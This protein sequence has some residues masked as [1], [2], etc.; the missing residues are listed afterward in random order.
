M[1]EISDPAYP[2]ERLMVC[3]NPLLAEQRARKRKELLDATER[4]VGPDPPMRSS[5]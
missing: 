3:R 2:D 1:G 4:E 5:A